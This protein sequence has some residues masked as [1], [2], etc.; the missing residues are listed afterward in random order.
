MD[1]SNATNY[2]HGIEKLK[3]NHGL[4]R[5]T[6][7][8]KTVFGSSK[9]HGGPRPSRLRG[10]RRGP[11]YCALLQNRTRMKGSPVQVLCR[12]DLKTQSPNR[13]RKEVQNN[14]YGPVM[15]ESL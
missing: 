10:V 4:P 1:V 14:Q 6:L 2:K 13:G 7:C 8:R 11:F 15:H 5:I 9:G 12:Q 3:R